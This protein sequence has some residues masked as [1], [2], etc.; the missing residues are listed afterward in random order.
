MSKKK[1]IVSSSN[2]GKIR[3]IKSILSDLDLEVLSKNE[4]GLLDLEVIEDKDTLEGNAIKKALEIH[5]HA[6]GMVMSDDSGLFVDY[7]NGDPG[8]HSARYSGIDGDDRANNKKLISKLSKTSLDER[9]AKFKTVIAL[10][11]EDGSIETVVGECSGK[12]ILEEKGDLGFG[13][14]PLF[15]PEGYEKTF[16]EL[17]EGT[18]NKISH[19]R[20]ALEKLKEK[21]KDIL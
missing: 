11:L 13:Y 12:I 5:K 14:D 4:V 16:A 18:K 15:I 9:G 20:E 3:E 21:L 1:L 7:L 17:D 6:K 8:V 2:V 10:V 19:R